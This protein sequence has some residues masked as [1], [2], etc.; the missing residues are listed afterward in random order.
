[1]R[2]SERGLRVI[3]LEREAAPATG[4]TGRSAAG[5]RVQFSEEVNVRLSA[6]S[7]AE[8]REMPQGGYRPIGYLFYVPHVYWEAHREAAQMQQRLGLPVEILDP[9]E[10]ARIVPADTAGFAGATFCSLDGHVDPHGITM[11]WLSQARAAG[12]VLQLNTAVRAIDRRGDR[13]RADAGERAF[14]AEWLVNAAGAWAGHVAAMAGLQVP[15]RPARRMVYTTAPLS[16]APAY[17]LTVDLDTGLWFR[18]EHDRLI[19]GMSNPDDTGF[20][21]GVDWNWL[22]TV[23]ESALRHFP[24]FETLAI[25]RRASWWGYYETTPDHQPI[26]GPMPG[27][28]AWYNACGFSGHGVQQAAA[29]GRVAAQ[30]IVGEPAFIDLT[31]LR[32]GRFASQG[33]RAERL[34][35]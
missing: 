6:A 10:A 26:V 25:D 13:W 3:V 33:S 8:Y 21:E 5:V 23:Y 28:P 24:W 4:S 18:P 17:P 27:A 14:E 7:I 29:I 30:E 19:F 20:A 9:A 22:E 32:I 11:A 15:V 35:V 34:I 31:P 2:L 1:R 12:A 16:P